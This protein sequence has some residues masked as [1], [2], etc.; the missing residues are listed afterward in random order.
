MNRISPV[1][2]S[3]GYIERFARPAALASIFNISTSTVQKWETR[4]KETCW[5]IKKPVGYHGKK[6]LGGSYLK[7]SKRVKS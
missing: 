7:P 3:V 4:Q 6:G 2:F 1:I 5:C